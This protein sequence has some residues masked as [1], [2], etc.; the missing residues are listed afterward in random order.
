MVMQGSSPFQVKKVR[1]TP[2][3]VHGRTLTPVARVVSAVQH[4]GTIRQGQ[5]EG[6]GWGMAYVQPLAVIESEDPLAQDGDGRMVPIPDATAT[7]LRQMAVMALVIPA[8]CL[9]VASIARWIRNR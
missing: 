6:M 5:I 1:G 7:V 3:Q 9:A 4:R 2:I 8:L